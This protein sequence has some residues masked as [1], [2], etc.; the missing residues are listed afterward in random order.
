[1]TEEEVRGLLRELGGDEVPAGVR[2][3]LRSRVEARVAQR[4]LRWWKW[5]FAVPAMSLVIWL[6]MG[7]T[8][9]AM[10]LPQIALRAPEVPAVPVRAAV[11]ARARVRRKPVTISAVEIRIE[12][13]D[14]DVVILLTGD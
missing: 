13:A 12:T 2:A 10:P 4:R 3:S 14:P 7:R 9:P 11:Y 8:D 6:L 1:M 5:A